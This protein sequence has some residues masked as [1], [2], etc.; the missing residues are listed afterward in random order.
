[1]IHVFRLMALSWFALAIQW[2]SVD[3]WAHATITVAIGVACYT[4][5]ERFNPAT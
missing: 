5:G 4:A 3:E 2:A 1:M